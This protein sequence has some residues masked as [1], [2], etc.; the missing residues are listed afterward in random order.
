MKSRKTRRRNNFKNIT[1]VVDTRA[2]HANLTYLREK[3]QT[4]VMPVLKANAYGHGLV[5]IA[6]LCRKFG[7]NYIGL[8]TLE[9]AMHLR[10]SGDRG[11]ILAWMYDA[12]SDQVKLAVR[13]N[14]EIAIFD[15][16]HIPIIS[17]SLTKRAK[18]HL[19]VDTGLNRS[20]VPYEDAYAAAQLLIQDPM[21]HLVG[22]MSHLCCAGVNEQET[23]AQYARF[24]ALRARL[25]AA[26]F[27][28]MYH[29]SATQ[30]ILKY[31]NS[32][33][34][35]VRSG[36]GLFGI[37]ESEDKHL[38]AVMTLESIL[39]QLKTVKKHRGVGY[40]QTY[41]THRDERIAVIPAG[42]A[43]FLPRVA[44]E[45]LSVFVNGSLRKVLGVESMDQIVVHANDS[46][47][48]GDKVVFFGDRNK[49]VPSAVQF[50]KMGGVYVLE[51][52]SHLGPRVRWLYV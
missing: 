30:G 47:K 33:F 25:A 11:R 52:L 41:V 50:A 23:K 19:F 43:D 39:V 40:F 37:E 28:G 20:G 51:I 29:I 9:E 2:L 5:E 13:K 7:A 3:S 48:L 34:D 46:D 8:A 6:R 42:Y 14:I 32:D 4:D 21:F 31:D 18:V 26:G 24:R 38:S 45:K 17:G 1:A 44:H 12:L 22:V 36:D 15:K 35:M 16:A 49:G 10:D 27:V